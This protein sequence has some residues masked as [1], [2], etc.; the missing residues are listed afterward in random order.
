MKKIKTYL[1][2]NLVIAIG[3][4]LILFSGL[5]FSAENRWFWFD[6]VYLAVIVGSIP[7][8]IDIISAMRRGVF[9]VDIIAI[10]AI[11]ASLATNEIIAAAIVVFMLS[12][13]ESLEKYAENKARSSLERLLRRAPTKASVYIDGELKVVNIKQVKVGDIIAIKKGEIIPVDGIVHDGASIVDESVITGEPMPRDVFVGD[14]V[15]SGTTNGG[16]FFTIEAKATYDKSVFSGIVRLVEQA[17]KE[18]APTVRLADRY[19]VY[20]TLFTFSMAGIAFFKDPHLATAVLV[21]ATPCPLILAAPIA[22]IAGMSRSAKR[23]IIVKHGGVFETILKAKAF[24]FDKTGTLTLGMPQVYSVK[25]FVQAMS[26]VDIVRYAASIEQVSVHVLAQGI[27]TKAIGDGLKL[28]T[29]TSA[30]ETTGSGVTGVLDGKE[31]SVGKLSFLESLGVYVSEEEKEKNKIKTKPTVYVAEGKILIGSIIFSDIVRKEVKEVL[32][33][34][35]SLQKNTEL[36]LITGDSETRAHEV[37]K[38]LGFTEIK[39]SCLPQDKVDLVKEYESRNK[40]VVMV[41]D[42]VNDAPS[43]A[44]ASV[45]IALGSHG[46]TA[47]TDIADAVI[48]VDDLDRLVYLIEISKKTTSIAKQSMGIG[49]GL[50]ILAMFFALFGY[51]PPI[52]GAIL[53]EGIDVLVI[54]NALRAL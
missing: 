43:L 48:M 51:L 34:L 54:I 19:S 17:E 20:F 35:L 18:K 32:K 33:D 39:A 46:A 15:V 22:F 37:G 25:T 52:E 14:S 6:I 3:M 12:G 30:T 24:F 2:I 8:V 5:F 23:G 31:Y 49:M 11:I 7:F 50:S 45:G 4:A 10:T 36:V 41:G 42:G 16:D 21:V 40:P 44:V 27:V 9:G 47:S 1:N 26:Q 53:Q 13:G 28:I 38:T 29:P